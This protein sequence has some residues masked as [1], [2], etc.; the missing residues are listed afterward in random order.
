MEFLRKVR[1]NLKDPK[2]KSLTLLGIYFVF[3]VFVFIVLS[4]ADNTSTSS[5][6]EETNVSVMDNYKDMESYQY[7]FS[8]TD[9]GLINVIE[10]TYYNNTSLFNYK[11]NKY[12]L[13]NN[14]LYIIDN[15]SYY[16]S[17]IE[18]DVTKLFSSNLYSILTDLTEESITT[19]NDGTREINYTMDA[20]KFYN[21]YFNV[22]SSYQTVIS[23]K[24]KEVD[25]NITNIVFDL[26]NLNIS[27][28]KVE[29]E[30]SNINNIKNLEFNKDNY[31]YR[32]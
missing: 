11:T 15:D 30:Y 8:Y 10:G 17:N 14:L 12:Y 29:I 6:P 16:I 1:E 21:Y 25:N 32:E 26:T 9:N 28:N 3:F 13:E 2:K 22:E 4:G 27:L 18:Y 31:T 7:K 24:V 19:Y 5:I 20:N 23:L